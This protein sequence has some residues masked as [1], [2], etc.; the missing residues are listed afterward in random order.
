MQWQD[1]LRTA[2]GFYLYFPRVSGRLAFSSF[3]SVS[4]FCNACFSL[5]GGYE[6]AE[7]LRVTMHP[8]HTATNN[9]A[10]FSQ[11]MF[12]VKTSAWNKARSPTSC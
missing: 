6:F 1:C 7:A 5:P 8:M 10:V 11:S 12:T 2:L 3:L 4:D 9:T